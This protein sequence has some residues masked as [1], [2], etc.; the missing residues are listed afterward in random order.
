[1]SF[2]TSTAPPASRTEVAFRSRDCPPADFDA[3]A[4]PIIGLHFFGIP[5]TRKASDT[6]DMAARL[7]RQRQIEHLYLLGPR[8]V[9]EFLNEVSEA[10]AL[11]RGLE[12]Y[13]RLTPGML[14]TLD[15]DRFP[16]IPVYEVKK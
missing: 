10:E 4:H 3:R 16:P 2:I 1:M 12:A 11:D 8:A 14:K 7:K 6:T 13:A 9:G 15:G 5:P